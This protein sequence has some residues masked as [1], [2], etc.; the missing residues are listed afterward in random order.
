[1]TKP[2]AS[3]AEKPAPQVPPVTR[4]VLG[5]ASSGRL[6]VLRGAGIDPLVVVSGVDEDTVAAAVDPDAGPAEVVRALARA[7]ADDVA[8]RLDPAVAADCV[9][10]GCDSM[11][12]I[13]GELAGKPSSVDEA[14]RRWQSM[15]GRAG[16]LHTGHCLIRLRDN[17]IRHQAAETVVTT[18]RFGTP[19]DD[20]LGAYLATGEPLRVAGGF[21]LDGLGGW[22]IDG[23]DGDPSSVIGISLPLLRSLL[24]GAGVSVATLWA[25]NP[26]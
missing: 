6:A 19:T 15:A 9:V 5:S 7:K 21:T 22:F 1:M 14:R 12:L 11:L 24:A 3:E 26:V 13:D 4:F 23:V 16:A 8:A 2:S 25:A 18:V 10:I 20:D 17:E